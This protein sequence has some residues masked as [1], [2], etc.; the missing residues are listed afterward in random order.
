M[1]HGISDAFVPIQPCHDFVAWFKATNQDVVLKEY[2]DTWLRLVAATTH[3]LR[4][5]PD[6]LLAHVAAPLN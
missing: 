1:F 3:S 5:V 6:A 2:L 4:L